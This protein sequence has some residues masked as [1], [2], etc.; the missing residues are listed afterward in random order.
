MDL[1]DLG[2]EDMPDIRSLTKLELENVPFDKRRWQCC[3]KHC[4]CATTI[5]DYGISPF[6]WW[7][8]KWIDLSRNIYICAKHHN[9][10]K[11]PA[12]PKDCFWYM[13]PP[14]YYKPG[15]GIDHLVT[16]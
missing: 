8:K 16:N 9:R 2:I 15:T 12:M 5:K 3:I 11:N 14:H 10:Y 1:P 6:F 13:I 7:R 4:S